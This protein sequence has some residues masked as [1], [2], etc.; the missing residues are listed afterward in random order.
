MGWTSYTDA[1]I[2]DAGIDNNSYV[3]VGSNNF[4]GRYKVHLFRLRND[5]NTNF[6]TFSVQAR[7]NKAPSSSPVYLQ[8][9]NIS[10]GD[11]ELVDTENSVA[12]NVEF[13]LSAEISTNISN[14]YN[15][16]YVVSFRIYQDTGV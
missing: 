12:A 5:N 2:D 3:S 16:S 6:I 9:Y 7:A 14:Y 10:S 1:Q 13:T 11:W 4:M 8:I 15:T